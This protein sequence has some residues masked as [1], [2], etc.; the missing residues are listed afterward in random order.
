MAHTASEEQAWPGEEIADGLFGSRRVWSQGEMSNFRISSSVS[1]HRCQVVFLLAHETSA[2]AKTAMSETLP[3]AS[4]AMISR[5]HGNLMSQP[6]ITFLQHIAIV[7]NAQ[8]GQASRRHNFP[9]YL[10]DIIQSTTVYL[11]TNMVLWHTSNSVA[12]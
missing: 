9:L 3:H 5:L 7:Q 12:V 10:P 2:F 11:P 4:H 1:H 8:V 6:D